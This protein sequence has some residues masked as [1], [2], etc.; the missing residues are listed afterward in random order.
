[1]TTWFECK[2]RYGK[3]MD[4][5]KDKN[6]NELYLVDALNFTEAENRII[7]E[8]RPFA[9]GELKILAIKRTNYEETF[10]CTAEG[11]DR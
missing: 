1:M 9:R 4:D 3:T 11:A 2:V 6:V 10:G 8:M 7:E 5:G